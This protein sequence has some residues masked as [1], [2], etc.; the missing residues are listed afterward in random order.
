[1]KRYLFLAL[2]ALG[3]LFPAAAQVVD[4]P[5]GFSSS[6]SCRVAVIGAGGQ[7]LGVF[8]LA[9]GATPAFNGSQIDLI[10]TGS[11]TAPTASDAAVIAVDSQ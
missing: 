4:C 6:G 11:T 10:P 1:M 3:C 8:G 5:S 2:M 7:S 9:N